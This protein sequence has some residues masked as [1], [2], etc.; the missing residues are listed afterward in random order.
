MVVEK[1]QCQLMG[2]APRP[3]TQQEQRQAME[4]AARQWVRERGLDATISS[5]EGSVSI[6]LPWSAQQ[7]QHQT[8]IEIN[9][10]IGAPAIDDRAD[11][12]CVI[13]FCTIPD[14]DDREKKFMCD[15]TQFCNACITQ[16]IQ[17]QTN[18]N[19]RPTCPL[20]RSI[21][22]A[23]AVPI[24]DR[25]TMTYNF[26][27]PVGSF[28]WDGNRSGSGEVTFSNGTGGEST[29]SLDQYNVI[30]IMSGLGGRAYST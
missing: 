10:P 5:L 1:T 26:N 4:E 8:N 3:L 29:M 23:G 25:V 20:C 9:R 14:T 2:P 27:H 7:L 11:D 12:D 17:V 28:L 6:H 16:S 18:P 13:C 30:R 21:C 24:R 22:K 15:H 19:G